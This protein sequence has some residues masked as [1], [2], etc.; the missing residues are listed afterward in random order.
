[1]RLTSHSALASPIGQKHIH[2][3]TPSQRRAPRLLP[4]LS[5]RADSWHTLLRP[6]WTFRKPL[7]CS[8]LDRNHPPGLER[9]AVET[10][11]SF[12]GA[13][14]QVSSPPPLQS[15]NKGPFVTTF[16][17]GLLTQRLPFAWPS[18]TPIGKLAQST[19]PPTPTR[20]GGRSLPPA[21]GSAREP[22]GPAGSSPRA[23]EAREASAAGRE[24]YLP[25]GARGLHGGGAG[26]A[27]G[28]G[29]RDAAVHRAAGR[30]A[31]SGSEA[32]RHC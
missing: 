25:C 29:I 7:P 13:R 5:S 24:A 20:P 2:T 21:C 32:A 4:E 28:Y 6:P 3:H 31:G 9:L 26:R 27:A 19:E 12:P 11:P 22:G 23:G 17:P 30:G 8:H 14:L 1:M 10:F 16:A 18:V 15:P